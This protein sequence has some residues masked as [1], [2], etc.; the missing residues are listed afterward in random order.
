MPAVPEGA[1]PIPDPV[2]Q[3][4]GQE[5]SSGSGGE[6]GSML[7]LTSFWSST[8]RREKLL[9]VLAIVGVCYGIFKQPETKTTTIID[10]K[11]V[12]VDRWHEQKLSKDWLNVHGL[13]GSTLKI[14]PDGTYVIVGPFDLTASRFSQSE[15]THDHTQTDTSHQQT[16]VEPAVAWRG[17]VKASFMVPIDHPLD[18]NQ[19]SWSLG[20]A[21]HLGQLSLLKL[22]F[23]IGGGG[24]VWKTAD[25]T[26]VGPMLLVTF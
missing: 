22:K 18:L 24:E 19:A 15:T 11:V 10:R 2:S 21:A 4:T 14:M 9:V 13:A 16:I 3:T 25:R 17:L 20:G 12:T 1:L 5:A 7:A 8:T 6:T 26:Y 23:D